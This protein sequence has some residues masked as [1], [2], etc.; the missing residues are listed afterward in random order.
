MLKRVAAVVMIAQGFWAMSTY[1]EISFKKNINYYFPPTSEPP[2]V[3][4]GMG[5]IADG[6]D[7]NTHSWG[8]N[9]I[10]VK[11]QGKT[12]YYWFG[13]DFK[14]PC[15]MESY[16]ANIQCSV[17]KSDSPTSGFSKIGSVKSF[18]SDSTT[19]PVWCNAAHAAVEPKYAANSD[20]VVG[21]AVSVYTSS[22]IPNVSKWTRGRLM[23][24]ASLLE[25][26]KDQFPEDFNQCAAGAAEEGNDFK[27]FVV[28]YKLIPCQNGDCKIRP[29]KNIM[30]ALEDN[31]TPWNTWVPAGMDG[32]S[33]AKKKLSVDIPDFTFSQGTKYFS[34]TIVNASPMVLAKDEGS[35]Q[36]N[37]IAAAQISPDT[38]KYAKFMT[39][40]RLGQFQEDKTAPARIFLTAWDAS[41]YL[42]ETNGMNFTKKGQAT[43]TG[44]NF[45]FLYQVTKHAEDPFVFLDNRDKPVIRVLVQDDNNDGP[46]WSFTSIQSGDTEYFPINQLADQT[47]KP[48]FVYGHDN[49]KYSSDASSWE[50]QTCVANKRQRPFIMFGE[51]PDQD[52]LWTSMRYLCGNPNEDVLTNI[53]GPGGNWKGFSLPV[54]ANIH[55]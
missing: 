51:K 37:D 23:S 43:V 18:A 54:I 41:K 9:I 35:V 27:A 26:Y 22:R 40:R 24:Q 38:K 30:A 34:K 6:P 15:G 10:R 36:A 21:W 53:T 42:W 44:N 47:S 2:T 28:H 39:F 49:I 52:I 1:A 20:Q 4:H 32:I 17:W 5:N 14:N 48:V 13:N 33:P 46:M 31:A 12:V 25:K 16:L 8:S 29:D 45:I 19:S 50:K 3:N 55:D 7:A 11:D